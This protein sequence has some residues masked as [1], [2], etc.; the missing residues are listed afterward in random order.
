M[1]DVCLVSMP[2]ARIESPSLAL[3]LLKS[4]LKS[5]HINS[6]A[7]YPNLWLAEELGIYK[8]KVFSELY[9][10]F[11]VGEWLFSS[12]AFP[13]FEPDDSKYFQSLKNCNKEFIDL[14]YETRE[15]AKKFV[16]RVA[17]DILD[18]QPLIVS[19]SSTFHQNCASLALLRRLRELKPSLITIMGGANCEGIMGLTL[20]QEFPWVDFVCSGEGEEIF[21]KLCSLLIEKGKNIN[22]HDLPYGVFGPKSGENLQNNEPKPRAVVTNFDQTPIPDFDDYFETLKSCNNISPYIS[23]GLFIETTRG[24]WWGAK[25]A[26]YLLWLEWTGNVI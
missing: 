24:C 5:S 9:A 11:F 23:P 2:F 1:T 12:S 10:E 25:T 6:R 8:Y 3:G 21:P 19:C 7:L 22:T 15:R 17:Q 18:I 14:L 20:H 4:S 16:D 26:L 13:D